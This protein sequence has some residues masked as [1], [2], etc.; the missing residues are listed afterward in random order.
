MFMH[1]A[2]TELK[3]PIRSSSLVA[4]GKACSGI[5]YELKVENAPRPSTPPN[6]PVN[7]RLEA[8][9]RS[10]LE[11]VSEGQEKR[12]KPSSRSQQPKN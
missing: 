6:S 8:Y 7:S 1:A 2:S 9:R 4:A 5:K 12:A 10:F 3:K 11:T